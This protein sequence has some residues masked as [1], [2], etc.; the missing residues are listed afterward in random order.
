M[1]METHRLPGDIERS[2]MAIIRQ[3]I[4]M[5]GVA[6]PPENESVILRVIHATAD[7]EYLETLRFSPDAARLGAEALRRGTP[8]VTDTNMALSGVSRPG[9]E[10]LGGAAY[11]F[12]AEPEIAAAAKQAGTTRAVAAVRHAALHY[13]GAI[14]AVGNA[15][16]ALL[17]I[18]DEIE[19]GLRPA[20]V[21]AVPVGFVNVV[22]SK[23]R[24]VSVCRAHG[25]PVI[26]AMGRKGGSSVAAAIVNALIYTASDLLDPAARGWS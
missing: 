20:L 23:K 9:L 24:I 26:A 16:T 8:I 25:V 14:L 18:A 17:Q 22:E 5:R 6:L 10:R 15:P 1:T 21:V 2:S 11:C 7:F 12:M 4:E 19:A 3:E 13:P